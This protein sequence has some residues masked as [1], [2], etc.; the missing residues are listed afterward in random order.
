MRLQVLVSTM[1]QKDYSLLDRMNIQCDAIIINQCDY[2]K[3]DRFKFRQHDIIWISMKERGIGISRNTALMHS[4]GD[5]I[6]F[7]DDDVVYDDGYVDIIINRFEEYFRDDI[8]LFNIEST[9]LLRPTNWKGFHKLKWYNCLKYGA[10]HFA[11]RRNSLLQANVF[12]SLL[13][14]GG[15]KYQSGEDSL[16]LQECLERG[17]RGYALSDKIG[18]VRQDT[19]SWFKG[20]NEKY[21]FDKGVLFQACFKRRSKL[22]LIVFLLK[23]RE[24]Y[25]K[26]GLK[27]AIDCSFK[28]ADHADHKEEFLTENL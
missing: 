9:N 22:L 8:L 13:F 3:V 5:V 1:N 7:S 23:N 20:Y 6:L 18:V 17:L 28:G 27:K 14:G 21:F 16:F 4:T 26:I 15:A 2:D 11:V 24:Q 10:I 19:S 12:F 25:S